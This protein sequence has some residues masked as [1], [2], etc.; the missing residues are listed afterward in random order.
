[1]YGPR[2]GL[3]L[4]FAKKVPRFLMSALALSKCWRR[5]QIFTVISA[6][7]FSVMIAAPRAARLAQQV[8]ALILLR[9]F[10]ASARGPVAATVFR[11]RGWLLPCAWIWTA[12]L[13]V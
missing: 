3:A 6:N 2:L 1:M 8:R 12:R 9:V 7:R 11:S 4:P 10:A 5:R 13:C